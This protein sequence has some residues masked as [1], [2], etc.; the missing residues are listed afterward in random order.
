[1]YLKVSYEQEFD[2]LMMYL[3]SKYPAKLFDLDGIGEQVDMSKFSKKF[4]SAN[5]TAD[6][7]IDAN[8]N[9]D[10]I[11]VIAYNTELPKPFFKLNSYY[12]LWKE[13]RRLYG[14]LIANEIIERQL[15]G[16]I[17]IHDFHGIAAGQPYS[18]Y[19][20][21][22]IV[23]NDNG[24]IIYSTMKEL[25]EHFAQKFSIESLPDR[26][27]I[28]LNNVTIL[29]NNNQWSELKYI[30]RHKSHTNLIKLETKN[31]FT[32]IVTT[33]HPVILE[34]G[35]EKYAKDLS[36]ND[37]LKLSNAVLPL[38]ESKQISEDYAY[39]TGFMIGDGWLQKR[40]GTKVDIRSG[41][42][43]ICQNN[44]KE[45]K[46]HTIVNKL[47]D[48]VSYN[49]KGNKIY[50]GYKKDVENL[51]STGLG[52]INRKLPNDILSWNK[53]AI[54]ALLSGIIDSD[55]NI[56]NQ[57]GMITIRV[58]SYELVQQIGELLRALNIGKVRVSFAG[59]YKSKLGFSSDNDV[60]R[61]S[62]RLTDKSFIQY[63][64]KVSNNNELVFKS[65]NIDG[66][67]ETNQL[68]K[69]EDWET[70]EYVYDITT[71]T[72]HF[73]CQGLI[74]HN[75]YNYSTYD[76]MTQGLPMVK[77]IKSKPPKYLYAFKSQ[78]EQ[79]TVIASNSTL[80]ATGLADMLIIMSYYVQQIIDT[81][82]D[83]HFE[84][85]N[86]DLALSFTEEQKLLYNSH[87][88][89]I[90]GKIISELNQKQL[91][92]YYQYG[93]YS[94]QLFESFTKKQHKAYYQA[95]AK[96]I[97]A[98]KETFSTE[99]NEMYLINIFNYVRENLVSFI[100]TINQPMRANQ[101][102]FTNIS[103]Y[104]K[105]FLEKLCGD[106]IF[107]DGST[108]DINLVQ[109]LQDLFLVIMNDEMERTPI[110]FPI[111]T[112]CFSIDE[113]NKLKD[114]EFLKFVAHHNKKYG[115]INIYGGDSS[116]LSSCC[117]IGEQKTLT[118]SSNGIN[119]MSFKELQE[120]SWDSTKR[121]FTIF[122]N[123]SW[124]KGKIVK[125]PKE[126]KK[127]YKI[128]T[129]N[130]KIIIV[131]E[132]HIN[133]TIEGN[134]STKLLT[135]NDYLMFNNMPINAF[136]EKDLKLTYEQGILIGAYLGDG[137]IYKRKDSNSV[138]VAYS[139]NEKKYQTLLPLIQKGLN[140]CN[141]TEEIHLNTEYNNVYPVNIYSEELEQF[142]RQWVSGDYGYEKE[143]D[144]NVISQSSEFRKGIID[145]YYSTDGGNSN[146]I[147]STSRK[148]IEQIETVFTSLG[149]NTVINESDRTDEKVVIREQEFNRNYPLYCIRWYEMKNKRSMQDIYIVKNN[150]PYFKIKNI[151]EYVDE[152]ED[153]YCFEM[154]N[155]NEPYFT[156]PNG[157]I[158]HNC[159]LRSETKSE[160]FNSFGSGSSKIG[161][162]GVCSINFPRLAINADKNEVAFF[163]ELKK[164]IEICAKV[165][166]A[167]RHI[168]RKR[169]ENGN[170]PLYTLGFCDLNTQYSTV[171]VNGLNECV[172]FMGKDILTEEGQKFTLN[173]IHTINTINKRY[174]K[175]YNAPHNCEQVPGENM[176][177]KMAEKDKL[178]GYQHTHNIYSNQ[179]I[180]LVTNADML[181][182][183]MLQAKFD[184][185][186]SGGA[187]C[188]VNVDTLIEDETKLEQLMET[189][190][191]IGV[192]YFAINYNLQECSN[193]HMTVGKGDTCS[194]CASPIVNNYTRVVG[195]LTNT[196]NWHKVR[197]EEDYPYRQ[198]YND[199]DTGEL[200]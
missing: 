64:E 187:I 199:I 90:K 14:Q 122:H 35:S 156:L 2:D 84:L 92:I 126:N 6:V 53:T 118:K 47:F 59:K 175:Q 13:L 147:Y 95:R 171:G 190:I 200:S 79:F 75:C 174:E 40:K 57:N 48:N 117:F 101:S 42:I 110:T 88:E 71:S 21:T 133:A 50:F 196:K 34:D 100:Y 11:S 8:A 37:K 150:S 127:L 74:Q 23:V 9:V 3:R 152:N 78:L 111:T 161:S 44:I 189:V 176:S 26:E 184:K 105:Y 115:F 66:R 38:T 82:A 41:N 158:T 168:V 93:F 4:F 85:I 65:I 154:N 39:M 182:R 183:I 15:A 137:S 106:Y 164:L 49:K 46:I 60:F 167:K 112:A 102:P 162:L 166:N 16:D 197:R 121:N 33:D 68:Y 108:P 157:I 178:L 77:K 80:G 165:N 130:N 128:T 20:K 138:V 72:G 5:T 87:M 36:L 195:F 29:D 52:S 58:I 148:L 191:E 51:L 188:H 146:R 99:Q 149:I 114:K 185:H 173:I 163:D 169:I 119:F 172:E 139:L 109:R 103:V 22:V 12:I 143:L 124:C 144:L 141:I 1:M 76:I 69:I 61:V 140:D 27:V 131:T 180:P 120:S 24:N 129:S 32:T 17:Y 89:E 151:E 19:E 145:G 55:G 113:N 97:K 25:F 98:L 94:M 123:G 194:I 186:F 62:I 10:D 31:G 18:Y 153:V 193:G 70:P 45:S 7:S 155:E 179:F 142:I 54:K 134:K 104:D 177:I 96:M 136:P 81:G 63:S 67:F 181:D 83:A 107:P 159:R 116:T 160:Y 170:Q 73:H 132:D 86:L 56:N 198:F 43:S 91:N 30:L 135:T 125:L 28:N 192:I